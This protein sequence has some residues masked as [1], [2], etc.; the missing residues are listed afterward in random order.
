SNYGNMRRTMDIA[1]L[2]SETI[3]TIL[4]SA[5]DLITFWWPY[6]TYTLGAQ[7]SI[8]AERV[9]PPKL[10]EMV[11]REIGIERTIEAQYLSELQAQAGP[12]N[13]EGSNMLSVVLYDILTLNPRLKV[14][15]LTSCGITG[16]TMSIIGNAFST[17]KSLLERLILNDNYISEEGGLRELSSGLAVHG[18]LVKELDISDCRLTS[19]DIDSI[20]TAFTAKL[21]NAISNDWTPVWLSLEDTIYG[22]TIDQIV[23][24]LTSF[25][26]NKVI[27]Y[28]DLSC[29]QIKVNK[30]VAFSLQDFM[31]AEKGCAVIG[32]ILKDNRYIKELN[33]RGEPDRQWGPSL[34]VQLTGLK[35]N[36]TLERLN[37]SG[38]SISGPDVRLLNEVLKFNSRL[39][40]L[41][42]DE[43]MALEFQEHIQNLDK[44]LSVSSREM[45]SREPFG[46]QDIII[47]KHLSSGKHS[48]LKSLDE[49]ENERNDTY[50]ENINE[51]KVETVNE[52]KI[53][54][55][56]LPKVEDEA[57]PKN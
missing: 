22:T 52:V 19:A 23:E 6:S 12:I 5:I 7:T 55:G 29:P 43:N 51:I 50:F 17:G 30:N 13:H 3:I 21:C 10:E 57:L 33:L 27:K 54:G 28:L 40:Y 26:S 42:I 45:F 37:I 53:E 25:C 39:K 31:T 2:F 48:T 15:D 34:G 18:S 11:I 14:L 35:T 1:S 49:D 20:M 4:R 56:T 44:R 16:E 36:D 41:S 9:K 8:P 38:N 47:N 24:V 46:V 32:K